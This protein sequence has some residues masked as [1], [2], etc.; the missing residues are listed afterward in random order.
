MTLP[1]ARAL[2][3]DNSAIRSLTSRPFNGAV[4][5]WHFR[6]VRDDARNEA[7][8]AALKRVVTPDSLVLDI[9]AGTGLLAM[10]AARAGA[11]SVVS[12][13]MNPAVADAAAD[14][15][16]L[17]GYAER[18]R[19]V[20]KRS[21]ELDVEG[22]MGGRADVLVSEIVSNDLLGEGALGVMED[23]VD[24]LLKPGGTMIP[25]HG[26]VRV[27]LA[28]WKGLDD[29]RL[30]DVAGFDVSPFN[31]LDYMPRMIKVGEPD[32]ALCSEHAVLFDFDFASGGPFPSREARVDL[33][34]QSGPINGVVQWI[35]L[36]LDPLTVY[37]NRPASGAS[38]CWAARFHPL[39]REITPTPGRVVIVHGAHTRV[40]VRFWAEA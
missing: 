35:R 36:Q 25:S 34:P 5:A 11:R 12:C 2:A 31:R 8:D 17:N 29:H 6:I 40:T 39:G 28:H 32:L 24:R 15:V 18:V 14:I 19:V 21:T 9:G 37:E 20:A 1:G 16:A 38:S 26:Q 4:P 23:A 7:Y 13:E 3:P 30:A 27:A 33:T 10:M 22:G